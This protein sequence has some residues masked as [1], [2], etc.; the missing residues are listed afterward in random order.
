M[1]SG[2]TEASYT[3]DTSLAGTEQYKCVI[4]NTVGGTPY[5]V[6][7]EIAAVTVRLSEITPPEI[8]RQPGTFTI[9]K[10]TL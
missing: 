6:E 1:I 4:T 3:P 7:S 2:A 10:L 9:G 8:I 5:I